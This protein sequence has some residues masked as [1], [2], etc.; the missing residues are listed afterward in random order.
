[1][2][3]ERTA[4]LGPPIQMCDALSRNLPKPLAVILGNCLAHAR[5]HVVEVIAQF[6][7]RVSPHPRDARE[8]YRHDAEAREQGLSPEGPPRVPPGAQRA[9]MDALQAWLTAQME[10]HRHRAELQLGPGHPLFLNHWTPLT[11][12]L[13]QP[14]APLDNNHLRTSPEEGDSPPKERPLLSRRRTARTSAISS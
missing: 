12:F 9:A 4:D 5:R 10:E 6:S 2:L 11:L 1:M 7:G 3:A 8:V 13:R 14:A